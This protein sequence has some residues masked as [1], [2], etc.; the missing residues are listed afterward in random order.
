MSLQHTLYHRL[1]VTLLF[2]LG[3]IFIAAAAWIMSL[4]GFTTVIMAPGQEFP[5][6]ASVFI[7]YA[8]FAGAIVDLL[9][10]VGDHACPRGPATHLSIWR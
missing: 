9:R 5:G 7:G 1:G 10:A 2:T 8:A 6:D 3:A 4:L